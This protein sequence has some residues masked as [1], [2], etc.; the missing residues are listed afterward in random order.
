MSDTFAYIFRDIRAVLGYYPLAVLIGFGL[1]MLFIF[2][3]KKK[4][5]R[6]G[7]KKTIVA[8]LFFSYTVMLLYITYFSREPGS[9]I[10]IDMELF[11]TWGEWPQSKA[12]FLENIL[13]FIPFGYCVPIVWRRMKNPFLLLLSAGMISVSIE[14][15]QYIT[16]RG[17]CQLDDVV[18]NIFGAFIGCLFYWVIHLILS[19]IMKGK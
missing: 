9:R 16:K 14:L 10:G 13:L 19:R 12:Y 1:T 7:K 15:I 18:T 11:G 8:F 4:H 6:L 5:W 17:Y 3:Y 2:I